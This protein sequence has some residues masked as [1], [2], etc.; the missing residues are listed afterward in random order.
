MYKAANLYDLPDSKVS[1]VDYLSD[2]EAL[3]FKLEEDMPSL[4]DF[5]QS[6]ISANSREED[7][8]IPLFSW[9]NSGSSPSAANM[10]RRFC[11]VTEYS[12]LWYNER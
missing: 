3:V 10:L 1:V 6:V 8:D 5:C 7:D 12:N 11:C 4:D 9:Y 2:V